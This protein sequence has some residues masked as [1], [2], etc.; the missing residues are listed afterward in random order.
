MPLSDIDAHC[1]KDEARAD[2]AH[3]K[4]DKFSDGSSEDGSIKRPS[5]GTAPVNPMGKIIV[6]VVVAI[7]AIAAALFYFQVI[8]GGSRDNGRGLNEP[9]SIDSW[10]IQN[11]TRTPRIWVNASD[12]NNNITNV[13]VEIVR[14]DLRTNANETVLVLYY[15]AYSRTVHLIEDID[16]NSGRTTQNESKVN[17]DGTLL[18][19]V[20]V[21]DANGTRSPTLSRN[22]TLPT[23]NL[24]PVMVNEVFVN[25]QNGMR[26]WANASD[27]DDAIYTVTVEIYVNNTPLGNP[28][29]V[30]VYYINQST[31]NVSDVISLG[32]L[33]AG[34][35]L[36]RAYAVDVL[37]KES[38][39]QGFYSFALPV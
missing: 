8:P 3:A 20:T 26:V 13:T 33:P 7:V 30:K 21:Q 36:I 12:P 39:F 5:S 32:S 10:T 4:V 15:A 27:S 19:K 34:D 23:M 18:V 2:G 11:N 29:L 14:Y 24:A 31:A 28:V 6:V 17:L 35:Y 37:E 22:I 25:S 9:P 16:F 1:E 38:E